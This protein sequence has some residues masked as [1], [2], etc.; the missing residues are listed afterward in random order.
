MLLLKRTL[1]CGCSFRGDGHIHGLFTVRTAQELMWGYEDPLLNVLQQILPAGTIP[2]TR[3]QLVPNMTDVSEA[4]AL[5]HTR[6]NTGQTNMSQVWNVSRQVNVAG[7]LPRPC[8]HYILWYC[9]CMLA[10]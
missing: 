10:T 8:G 5:P 7:A 6:V 3:V 9:H 4:H 1:V 2:T